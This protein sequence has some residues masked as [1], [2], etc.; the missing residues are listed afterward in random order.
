MS[1]IESI[2]F[3]C[4]IVL[5]AS[6]VQGTVGFGFSLIAVPLL[7]FVI[8]VKTVVPM[9]VCY[10]L[11]NNIVVVSWAIKHINLKRIWI[12]IICGIIG[13]PIGVYGLKN[14]NPEILKGIIGILIILTSIFMFKGY[15]V[16]FKRQKLSYGLTGFISGILN[17]SLSMS[18]PPIVLFLSNEGYD[19]NEFRANLAIYATITNIITI[20]VFIFNRLLTTQMAGIM[21]ANIVTILIGSMLGI[22]VAKKIKDHHFRGI[23]LILLAIVGLITILKIIL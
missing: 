20:F 4:V 1:G 15:K 11:V 9:V 19:K 12:M 22:T 5:I 6:T 14:I 13:I 2:I 23:V 18:G 10:S 7:S 16:H 17:G 8:P 21:G 3:S